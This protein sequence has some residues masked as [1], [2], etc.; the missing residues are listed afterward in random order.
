MISVCIV[1][2]NGENYIKA[3]IETIISQL[4][5]E[6]EIIVSDDGSTDRTIEIIKKINDD[7]IK[8]FFHTRKTKRSK[9]PFF[10]ISQNIENALNKAKGDFIFLADQDDIW[11]KKKIKTTLTEIENNLCILHDCNVIDENGIE[12]YPSYY[13]LNKSKLGIVSNLINCSYLGCCMA[14][15]KE[16]LKDALPFPSLPVPH[17]IWLGLI[18]EWKGG[19]KLVNHKL[20]SYRRHSTNLSTASKKSNACFSYKVQ[21]RLYIL[22]AFLARVIVKRK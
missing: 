13:A 4:G 8:I 10:H 18:A 1:T 11:N 16:I 9:F 19:L 17:D 12:L 2:F 20:I 7:R 21:Y 5:T 14:F 6:D 15:R 3:Q 22:I